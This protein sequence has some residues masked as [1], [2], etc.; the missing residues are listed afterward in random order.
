LILGESQRWLRPAPVLVGVFSCAAL[1]ACAAGEDSG[2][3]ALLELERLCFVPPAE[4]RLPPN[5]DLSVSEPI[6][7]DRF[8]FTRADLRH[9]WPEGR[10]RAA[11]YAWKSPAAAEAPER[12]DWPAFVDFQEACA[13]AEQRGMRLPRPN[14]WLHVALG[15]VGYVSPWGGREFFANTVVIQDGADFSLQTPCSVGTY[16]NGRSRPF[17]CYDLLGNA[18]EWVDGVVL[19]NVYVGDNERPWDE[20]DDGCGTRASVLGGAF[21]SP[22]RPTYEFDRNTNQQR[23]HAR[24][25]DKRTLSPS[26]GVRM[27]AEAGPYL[28]SKAAAWGKGVA[29][30]ERVRAVGRVWAEDALARSALRG[31]LQEL[32]ARPEAPQGLAWLEEG[33]LAEP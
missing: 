28:W 10:E 26:I 6:V 16:E 7:F 24:L 21:D 27:C 25:L 9:Y 14:E 22:W 17:G 11:D 31:L 8:E 20:Q 12:A 5:S 15:R 33:V 23:F 13:L 1:G 4:C 19:D 29:V 2:A 30:R 32:R 18:W 3:R